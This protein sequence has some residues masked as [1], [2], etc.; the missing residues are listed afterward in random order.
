MFYR[1]I[2]MY[3]S[4]TQTTLAS[5]QQKKKDFIIDEK[6]LH[7]LQPAML[8]YFFEIFVL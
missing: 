1:E 8:V 5:S 7:E 3:E 6:L 2:E 4:H